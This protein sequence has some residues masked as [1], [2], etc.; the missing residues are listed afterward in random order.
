M[1]N[2]PKF[3]KFLTL[4]TAAY[5]VFALLFT[6]VQPAGAASDATI[7][8]IQDINLRALIGDT[9]GKKSDNI[10]VGDLRQMEK[11]DNKGKVIE[12]LSGLEYATNLQELKL[13]D[14]R[15]KNINFVSN[16]TSLR[17]LDL[18]GNAIID[19]HPLRNLTNLNELI[20][21]N[22]KIADISPLSGLTDLYNLNLE[23]NQIQDISPVGNLRNIINL[24]LAS[25][26]IS[27][28][29]PLSRLIFLQRL[30]L[31]TNQ[32]DDI[33]P[34]LQ[35]HQNGAK[36]MQMNLSMNRLSLAEST[37]SGK[38]IKT[39]TDN[40]YTINALPQKTIQVQIDGAYLAMDVPPAVINGRTLVP[41]RAIFEALGA[42]VDW[43]PATRT[44]TGSRG[45]ITMS[46][47]INNRQARVNGEIVMMDVAGTIVD[48]RTMVPA[49][50][51]AE[52]LGRH[53]EWNDT[54][55]IVVI[56]Q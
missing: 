33:S 31:S 3:L 55:R 20:L 19:L 40:Y 49:R 16:M 9:V 27:D 10:T 29:A 18:S 17:S 12:N 42:S 6:G 41:L 4:L 44:V 5:F 15:I 21:Y 22:N 36:D 28:I 14:C 11:F 38:I 39:L 23:I 34:L 43:N 24:N 46:L 52:S 7:V 53:V 54:H 32:I 45:D 47:T 50:F 8:P 51:I 25:N 37:P 2:K 26:N 1:M 48:G 30:N 56:K 13:T 35:L